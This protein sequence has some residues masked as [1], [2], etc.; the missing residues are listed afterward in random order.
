MSVFRYDPNAIKTWA[1]KIARYMDGDIQE[2][3]NNFKSQTD[4]LSQPG[5]WTGDAAVK[6]YQNF[7]ETH[8]ALI[9]FVNS[10]GESFQNA[11]NAVNQNIANLEVSNLGT[12]TNV[13]AGLN[14]TYSNISEVAPETIKSDMVTYDYAQ[15]Q[16]IGESLANIKTNLTET[17]NRLKDSVNEINNGEGLWDGD[18]AGRAHEE[19][20]TTLTTNMDKVL[21]SLEICINNIKAAG[22]NAQEADAA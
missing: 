4:I 17:Y 10:F 6:N 15:I 12:E 8:Q 20:Y 13:A 7:V 5:V 2:C 11:M 16:S 3:S 14:L 19:L 18:A 22:Q 9:R 21:E 1:D